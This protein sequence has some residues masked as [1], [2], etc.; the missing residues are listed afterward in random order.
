MKKNLIALLSGSIFSIGLVISG[1][2]NPKKVIG[3]L[4][5]FGDWDP[6]LV[7]VMAGAVVFNF[8]SFRFIFK[9]KPLCDTQ[10]QLPANSSIDKKLVIGSIIFGIGWGLSGICPG[11]GIVNIITAKSEIFYFMTSLFLG[12]FLFSLFDKKSA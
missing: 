11:P 3:F 8:I 6:S 4:D 5:I 9:R 1:M 7:F 2:T 12:I 10:H